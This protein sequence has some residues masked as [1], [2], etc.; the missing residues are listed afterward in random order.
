MTRGSINSNYLSH[1]GNT[2]TRDFLSIEVDPT[3][4]I[5]IPVYLTKKERKKL[6]RQ[7]RQEAQKDLQEKIRIGLAPQPEPKG[8]ITS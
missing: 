3:K 1:K 8:N 5:N 4:E 7:N 6:R 2:F